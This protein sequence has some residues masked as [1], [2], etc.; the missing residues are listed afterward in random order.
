MTQSKGAL[1]GRTSASKAPFCFGEEEYQSAPGRAFGSAS[2]GVGYRFMGKI[3]D[4]L[5]FS[6]FLVKP[7]RG[8]G[9]PGFIVCMKFAGH[10]QMVTSPTSI[11]PDGSMA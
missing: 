3:R 10:R 9:R 2:R 6:F 5:F 1:D 4:A 8:S 11:W 7:G